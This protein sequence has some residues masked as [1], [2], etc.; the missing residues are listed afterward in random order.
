[1]EKF[2]IDLQIEK[3]IHTTNGFENLDLKIQIKKNSFV[4]IF[5]KSGVGKTTLLRI[6]AG[7]EIPD[8]GYIIVDGETWFD[9]K[10]KINIK[11]QKRNIGF[12]FQDYALFPNMTVKENILFAQAELEREYVSKLLDMFQLKGL[13][14][15]KPAKLSGGQQQ[16]L[17]VARAFAR[18]PKI[19]LLDEPLSAL[20]NDTRKL[21]QQE[22]LQAHKNFKAT[23]ILVSHDIKEVLK[24]SDY[25]YI[26]DD[27]IVQKQGK[28]EHIFNNTISS[29]MFKLKAKIIDIQN[30]TLTV[31]YNNITTK[32]ECTDSRDYKINDTI[33][34]NA[35]SQNADIN[36]ETFNDN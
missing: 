35:I 2:L 5:G 9:S 22:I 32:I 20:D 1:M 30:N 10:K 16:R 26:I 13:C 24:M 18:K 4:T 19:L 34:I 28:P 31:N 6:L 3:K 14:N 7:L 27:G 21:L 33:I 29:T 12:V 25:V 11:A 23:T 17:A 15:R 36:I 8:K